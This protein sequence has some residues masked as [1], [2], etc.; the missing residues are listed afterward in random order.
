MAA[1]IRNHDT[2]IKIIPT[3]NIKIDLNEEICGPCPIRTDV[4]LVWTASALSHTSLKALR[5]YFILTA[6]KS[7]VNN[8][9]STNIGSIIPK[10]GTYVCS[11]AIIRQVLIT[12]NATAE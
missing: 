10:K 3:I 6:M 8:K 1:D 7:T 12:A 4:P 5:N 11:L 2:I 9:N